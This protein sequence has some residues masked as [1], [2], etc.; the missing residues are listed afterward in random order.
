MKSLLFVIVAALVLVVSVSAQTS[1]SLWPYYVEVTPEKTDGQIYDLAVPLPVMDRASTDLADLRL[2]DSANREIPYAIRI[3]REVDEKR[4]IP[5]RL[6]NHG[7]AG[8]STS[9]VSVDL[10]ENPGEHNEIDIETYGANF[11]RQVVV[12]GSDSGREW[13]MLSNDGVI[14]N[15]ASQNNVAESQKVS[16]PT[17]RYRYL[18]VKVSRDP[19]T[20]DE[21]PQVTSAKVM[22]VVREKGWLSTWNVPVPSYQLQRNQGAHATVWT[23]DLGG[24]IPCD[25]LSIEIED[26]SFSRPFQVESIDDPQNVRLLASG[27]LNRHSGEE[28][29]PLVIYFDKEAVV[30]KLRLQ[31]TD[32]SNPTLSITSINA[33]APARQLV[34]EMKAPAALPLRLF[35]GKENLPA[36]HY[37]FE[38]EVTARLTKEPVHSQLGDVLANRDYK[39]E[40][41]PLT[42]RVPWLIYVVLAASSIALAFVLWS[43]A[44]TATR[45]K[46]QPTS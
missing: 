15:F 29:K 14:F 22:M 19:M 38:K 7:Y 30:R 2:F 25:R 46:T 42:E 8:P 13:R 36:P 43:L 26:D 40:P 16:Y 18:R 37:D 3:R 4:E 24:R 45:L 41:K 21:T 44:R 23:L 1:L 12:E 33:S 39:P 9:E 32:Y 27:D 5:A 10:G 28:T 34:Y 17:S 6:F 35:F 20:D 31:I 11:R